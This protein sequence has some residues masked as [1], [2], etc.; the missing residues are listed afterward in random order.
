MKLV[1]PLSKR[2]HRCEPRNPAPPVTRMRFS[3]CMDCSTE[4][5]LWRWRKMRCCAVII[6][7]KSIRKPGRQ[8]SLPVANILPTCQRASVQSCL[9]TTA[10]PAGF[11]ALPALISNEDQPRTEP[12]RV[13]SGHNH[14]PIRRDPDENLRS[15]Q[16]CPFQGSS[17]CGRLASLGC[18]SIAEETSIK[19]ADRRQ[20][21][22]QE[23]GCA[24]PSLNVLDAA[25]A[26]NW[27]A[28]L[29]G[30]G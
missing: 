19:H 21:L 25:A 20:C 17:R 1:P 30:V 28:P 14:A 7:S 29:R 13:G 15:L 6:N 18:L 2:L 4:G 8:I 11:G 16:S 9:P 26:T 5:L 24:G 12:R 22:G 23:I 27:Q 10:I 3:R